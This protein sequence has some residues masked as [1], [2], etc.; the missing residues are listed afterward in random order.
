M[1]LFK[2]IKEKINQQSFSKVNKENILTQEE[3]QEYLSKADSESKN[4]LLNKTI[5]KTDNIFESNSYNYYSAAHN[6]LDDEYHKLNSNKNN[7]T[8]SKSNFKISQLAFVMVGNR[9][10][11]ISLNCKVNIHLIQNNILKRLKEYATN[12]DFPLYNKELIDI[13]LEIIL[14]EDY[15]SIN[16]INILDKEFLKIY[17]EYFDLIENDYINFILGHDKYFKENIKKNI[18][19]NKDNT[20]FDNFSLE[21]K[22]K[23]LMKEEFEKSQSVN[24]NTE[25]D[26]DLSLSNFAY[27]FQANKILSL[28]NDTYKLIYKLIKEDLR[29]GIIIHIE[30]FDSILNYI[31]HIDTIKVIYKSGVNKSINNKVFSHI[32]DNVAFENFLKENNLFNKYNIK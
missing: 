20:L 1:N 5:K 29:N 27:E 6:Y 14:F 16:R 31:D 9:F 21:A 32:K 4:N 23:E 17:K 10:P 19:N 26:N 30:L 7:N 22:N 11:I 13:N 15:S 8:D 24:E 25:E 2:K 18:E 28:T 3:S 12:I